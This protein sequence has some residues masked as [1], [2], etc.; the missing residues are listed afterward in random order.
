MSSLL[1]SVTRV[2]IAC[3]ELASDADPSTRDVLDQLAMVE[4][5]VGVLGLPCSSETVPGGRVWQLAEVTPPGAVVFN[6][7]EAPPGLPLRHAAATTVLELLGVPFTGC[8]AAAMWLTTD[9]LATRAVLAAAGLPVA[10]GG[11]VDPRAP[12][13]PR[14]VE[15]PVI[16]KLVWED[17][18]VGLEGNPICRNQVELAG[19]VG[20]LA[21][22]FP[23]QPVMVEEFLPGREFNV[24]I[25]EGQEGPEVLPVAEMTFPDIPPEVPPIVSYEAKW[26]PGT[27]ADLHT[28]RR[29]PTEEEDGELLGRLRALVLAAWE[30]CGLAGYARVDLR[31]DARGEPHILEVNANPCLDPQVGFMVAAGRAGL[32]P[33]AVVRALLEGAVRRHRGVGG[34][35][36]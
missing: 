35:T 11:R 1:P 23:G 5:A 4:A 14:G 8:S 24:A 22:R 18:S 17:A 16:V 15:F 33:P 29:F 10:P 25:L 3:P 6:L 19:R 12:E 34:Q 9:K 36:G 13:L 27:P 30:A 7:L 26:L 32:D 2:V 21:E 20:W 31:L 28:A